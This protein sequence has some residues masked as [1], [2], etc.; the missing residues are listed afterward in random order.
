M[1]A[2]IA[3]EI[4]DLEE[5]TEVLDEQTHLLNGEGRGEAE[6]QR[7]ET[8]DED[9][10]EFAYR[11]L[12]TECYRLPSWKQ[13]TPTILLW[14]LFVLLF[15]ES[16][17]VAAQVDRFIE[18]ICEDVFPG[19]PLEDRDQQCRAPI[20]M[21]ELASL[22]MY[23]ELI[24]GI[25]S[26]SVLPVLVS[27]SDR[28][29]RRP[30]IVFCTVVTLIN[31]VFNTTYMISRP[32]FSYKILY[33]TSVLA[34]VGSGQAGALI[35]AYPY[36]SDCIKN[37]KRAKYF[38]MMEG[39]QVGAVALAPNLGA[40]LF[41]SRGN[42][43]L[44]L[45]MSVGGLSLSLVAVV[46][47]I[48][49][50]RSQKERLISQAVYDEQQIAIS[51][52]S[53]WARVFDSMN[54]FKPL[55]AL[56]FSHIEDKSRRLIPM[57]LLSL[58]AMALVVL[59]YE[60]APL[61]MLLEM[62]F[63]WRAREIGIVMTILGVVGS[64]SLTVLVPILLRVLGKIYQ[65]SNTSIDKI[66]KRII[67]IGCLCLLVGSLCMAFTETSAMF[68]LGL[69]ACELLGVVSP[70]IQSVVIKYADEKQ[71]GLIFGAMSQVVQMSVIVGQAVGL[72]SF[73]FFLDIDAKMN[74]YIGTLIWTITIIV[75][76][77]ILR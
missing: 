16:L 48:G 42:M 57:V 46:L 33:V 37:S 53:P 70:V 56:K 23:T 28:I 55:E 3:N 49:E 66:D 50:S 71:I 31:M 17:I 61:Q 36:I 29:G 26:F 59:M 14:S 13:P 68:L 52:M 39:F 44:L 38:T 25:V 5:V 4:A 58:K 35:M 15:S 20:V 75:V 74:I 30:L 77:N 51:A 73:K 54:I 40:Q 72:G 47:L 8:A 34:G 60:L 24:K 7:D 22:S 19:I 21:T 69:C 62:A 65:T 41:K 32:I 11:D 43:D 45:A 18:L 63:H 67:N 9:E 76:F 12:K 2:P 6:G 10:D 27:L 64:F 1:S